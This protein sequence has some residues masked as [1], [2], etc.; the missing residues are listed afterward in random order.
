VLKTGLL[1]GLLLGF[2]LAVFSFSF[3]LSAIVHSR[4]VI[5]TAWFWGGLTALAGLY[6]GLQFE[7]S[8]WNQMNDLFLP[9]S[10]DRERGWFMGRSLG[11][12]G[13]RKLVRTPRDYASHRL[14]ALGDS[15]AR[16]NRFGA[17]AGFSPGETIPEISLGEGAHHSGAILGLP[18][19][20]NVFL[21]QIGRVGS[22]LLGVPRS[23]GTEPD[24]V[25]RRFGGAFTEEGYQFRT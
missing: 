13:A 19:G 16:R 12:I 25:A 1:Y 15:L 6:L 7:E 11:F 14:V 9:A 18:D 22:A 8:V 5:F 17:L 3:V 2:P 4:F 21:V 24:Q 20:H 10:A 23:T